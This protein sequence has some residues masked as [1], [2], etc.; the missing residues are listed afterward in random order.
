MPEPRRVEA[1][2]G[3]PTP[4][5]AA[6]RDQ[7]TEGSGTLTPPPPSPAPP[8]PTPGAA[9]LPSPAPSELAPAGPSPA[10]SAAAAASSAALQAAAGDPAGRFQLAP[11]PHVWQK[12]NNCGPS[13][14]VMALAP[15]GRSLDQLAVAAAL[16]PDREDTNVTPEELAAFARAQGFEA[17][18]RLGGDRDLAR[19]LVQ[20]GAPV[21]AEH[22]IDVEGRGEMGHYRV[23]VGYDN[24]EGVLIVN[25]SYYGAGRRIPF[26]DFEAMGQPFLGA[27]V[28]VYTPETAPLVQ[29]I[30]GPDMDEQANARRM[31]AAEEARAAAEPANAWAWYAL[32]EVRARLGDH[33]GAVAA[34]DRAIAIGLPFR[35]FWYQ[36]GY[37]RALIETGAHERALQHADATIET[38]KGEN[39]EES[40]YW[41]GVALER[42]GRPDEARASFARALDFNPLF[43]AAQAALEGGGS[44]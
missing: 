26:A 33:P 40:H 42:L 31:L 3:V 6:L 12:W 14:L 7:G 43:A 28:V 2:I 8:S 30:L 21:I 32:G 37:Y 29:A 13:A 10:P 1:T 17:L 23:V 36:F 39:L 4:R 34:F 27:Y 20:A 38:M 5:G 44:P 24:A 41:R 18:V 25:D 15:L 22:W 11:A 16:K 35:A 19:A 9:T